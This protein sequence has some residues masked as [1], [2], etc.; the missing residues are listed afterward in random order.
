MNRRG[1]QNHAVVV[2]DRKAVCMDVE[3]IIT[4]KIRFDKGQGMAGSQQFLQ[5]GLPLFRLIRGSVVVFP[6]KL[7]RIGFP[8]RRKVPV[9]SRIAL[10]ALENFQKFH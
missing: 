7:L 4:V 8:I 6:T 3:A 10:R 2:D 9:L 5:N 1:I